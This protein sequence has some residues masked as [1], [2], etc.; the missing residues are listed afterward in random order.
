M[1]IAAL[2]PY[3]R[4]EL[5]L[6]VIS[7]IGWMAGMICLPMLYAYHCK[8]IAGS[9]EAM[10]FAELE[11]VLFKRLVN[12]AMNLAFLFGILLILTPGA[13]S[14]SACWWWVKLIGV[15]LLSGFHGELSRWRRALRDNRNR[16]SQ[17]FYS[18]TAAVPIGL[19]VMIVIMVIVRP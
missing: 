19:A 1:T 17:R 6:H 5:S 3:Y 9:A 11:R 13:I 10:Q 18:L 16:R 7:V 15:F 14:W 2:L 8:V 12:P 4:W